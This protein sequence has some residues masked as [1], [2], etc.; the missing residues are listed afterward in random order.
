MK[1]WCVKGGFSFQGFNRQKDLCN[2]VRARVG[3][4]V[5]NVE[6]IRISCVEWNLKGRCRSGAVDMGQPSILLVQLLLIVKFGLID[7]RIDLGLSYEG[8]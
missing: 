3:D 4:C 7:D 5:C 2:V 8:Q 1:G 6:Y